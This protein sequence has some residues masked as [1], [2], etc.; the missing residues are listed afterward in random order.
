MHHSW[1]SDELSVCVFYFNTDLIIW[2]VL[3]FVRHIG[4][5]EFYER[6]SSGSSSEFHWWYLSCWSSSH[7]N[8]DHPRALS[9]LVHEHVLLNLVSGLKDFHWHNQNSMGC[10]TDSLLCKFCFGQRYY[11]FEKKKKCS[12]KVLIDWQCLVA[13][14][15]TQVPTREVSIRRG[16]ALY[17]D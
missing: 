8:L 4:Y 1:K 16:V 7:T 2:K 11:W 15:H 17:L 12:S 14:P 5:L 3:H 9:T 10:N 6:Y 13:T